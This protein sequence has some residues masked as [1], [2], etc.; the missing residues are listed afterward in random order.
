[1]SLAARPD[2]PSSVDASHLLEGENDVGELA[3]IER[4]PP[5][6]ATAPMDQSSRFLARPSSPQKPPSSIVGGYAGLP[7]LATIWTSSSPPIMFIQTVDFTVVQKGMECHLRLL[8][9]N[10]PA[11]LASLLSTEEWDGLRERFDEIGVRVRWDVY[12]S[13]ILLV[14]IFV[15]V[16]IVNSGDEIGERF[17]LGDTRISIL[18]VLG[19]ILVKLLWDECYENYMRRIIFHEIDTVCKEYSALMRPRGAALAFRFAD[20]DDHGLLSDLVFYKVETAEE[21]MLS[22][23]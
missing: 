9:M 6:I 7:N 12:R 19:V 3:G 2:P 8:V 20:N 15:M 11:G 22:I 16:V 5:L 17:D 4:V 23:P 1:M 10:R 13:L 14:L 18:I 21:K